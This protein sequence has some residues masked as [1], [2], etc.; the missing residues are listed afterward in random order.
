MGMQPCGWWSWWAC[1]FL[2]LQ[3]PFM[4]PILSVQTNLALE[5]E[6]LE[7]RFGYHREDCQATKV[8]GEGD[9]RDRKGCACG[10]EVPWS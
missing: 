5:K 9:G 1:H 2:D 7:W 3:T 6:M 10:N 8:L 4:V